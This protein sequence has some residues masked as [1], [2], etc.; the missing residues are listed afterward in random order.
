[1]DIADVLQYGKQHGVGELLWVEWK[2][3]QR[4]IDVAFPLYE[5]WGAAGVKVDLM[6]H[7]NQEMVNYYAEVAQKAAEHHLLVY[8][9]GAYKPTGM[10]RTYPNVLNEEG[11]MGMEH[12]KLAGLLPDEWAGH[13]T[14][15]YD[16]TLPF[17]RMLAGP[18]DYTPGSFVMPLV[19]S[20]KCNG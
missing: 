6:D 18:M 7:D 8:F 11:V 5:K 3:L 12:D 14:P 15:E 20:S 1:V 2:A 10:Q 4:Q 9:H 16:V 17:T 19:T 13:V